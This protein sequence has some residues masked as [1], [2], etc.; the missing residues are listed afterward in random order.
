MAIDIE[1]AK[2]WDTIYER[3]GL[4]TYSISKPEIGLDEIAYVDKIDI[5]KNISINVNNFEEFDT[6]L[7]IGWLIGNKT[8]LITTPFI[9]YNEIFVQDCNEGDIEY[10]TGSYQKYYI[11]QRFIDWKNKVN[12]AFTNPPILLPAMEAYYYERA[13]NEAWSPKVFIGLNKIY[14][15]NKY[16]LNKLEMLNSLDS[17]ANIDIPCMLINKKELLTEVRWGVIDIYV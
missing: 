5:S 8:I 2:I 13:F 9:L 15:D 6:I 4:N 17:I 3:D 16:S 11:D 7:K 1:G 12:K 14:F 10:T